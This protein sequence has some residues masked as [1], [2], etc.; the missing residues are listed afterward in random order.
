M[1]R[2]LQLGR[3]V[4]HEARPVLR[5]VVGLKDQH[6][7]K[8]TPSFGGSP[9]FPQIHARKDGARTLLQTQMLSQASMKLKT[10]RWPGVKS[11]ASRGD[12]PKMQATQ[13]DIF[14]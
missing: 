12:P 9:L 14:K 10:S 4:D 2:R 13:S 5:G 6:L 11:H 7:G 3:G 8:G 1:D